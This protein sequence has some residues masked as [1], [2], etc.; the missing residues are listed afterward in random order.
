MAKFHSDRRDFLR[1]LIGG[2]AGLSFAYTGFG[3][4]APPAIKATKLS[5]RV[6]L[7][8]GDGGNVAV[9]IGDDGLMMIDG[10]LAERAMDL[11]NAVKELDSHPVRILFNTHWH[12]DH[13][14]S[15]ELLGKSGA[16]IIGH[17]NVK[18]Y[19][20]MKVTMETMNRTFDPLSP[21][22]R[23][24]ET[25]TKGGKMSF[26]KEKLEYTHHAPAHT[27]SD[28]YVFLPESNILHCG[29]LLFNGFYPVIDYSTHGWVGGMAAAAETLS[30][31]GD[32]KTQVIPGHGPLA[33]KDDL[34][35]THEMLAAVTER[36][37]PMAKA[38]KTADEVVAAA[39]TKD[40][41]DKFGHGMFQPAVWTRIA[42]TS[43]LRH[44]QTSKT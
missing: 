40:F 36:M 28:A 27:D 3:Q 13:V 15:N 1:A 11:Q 12:F 8:S 31:V 22:G 17:E 26:G 24:A 39:P 35:R 41:D 42:Y 34:K 32:A 18:K 37:L 4:Q 23:P 20:G 43:I 19:L 30:K 21:E 5:G 25:F 44:N 29:D 33:T 9:I 16:R 10:G 7:L 2:A 38:G 14:G 6:A